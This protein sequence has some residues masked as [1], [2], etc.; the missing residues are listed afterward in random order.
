LEDQTEN[1]QVLK[2]AKQKNYFIFTFLRNPYL[3]SV[4][5]YYYTKLKAKGN[6]KLKSFREWII[7]PEG[8]LSP[9]HWSSQLGCLVKSGLYSDINYIGAT[10]TL[11]TDMNAIIKILNQRIVLQQSKLPLLPPYNV[12][13]NE[14]NPT[15]HPNVCEMDCGNLPCAEIIQQ[16]YP[17]DTSLLPYDP[18][19][20][21]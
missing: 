11:D 15:N 21:L 19:K 17:I 3:R 12:P 20:C 10:E 7:A 18:P 8:L 16:T 6:A 13:K 14:T 2:R 5:S 1:R 4:S 9:I